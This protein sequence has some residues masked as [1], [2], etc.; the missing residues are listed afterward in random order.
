MCVCQTVLVMNQIAKEVY[1]AKVLH[2]YLYLTNLFLIVYYYT[3]GYKSVYHRATVNA[4]K[5]ESF[6]GSLA[7]RI[8]RY[9]GLTML[10]T[11]HW[12]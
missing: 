8:L 4:E 6:R 5:Y 10:K 2:V 7:W 3:G 9:S 1:Y 11:P 12:Q